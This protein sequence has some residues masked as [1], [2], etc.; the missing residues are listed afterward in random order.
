LNPVV[1]VVRVAQDG[2]FEGGVN[3][4]VVH[5]ETWIE[6]QL[7]Q[8]K[9]DNGEYAYTPTRNQTAISVDASDVSRL[10]FEGSSGTGHRFNIVESFRFTIADNP[11]LIS[12][13]SENVGLGH[14]FLRSMER[15]LALAYI[16]DLSGSAPWDELRILREELEKYQPGMSNKARVVIANKADLLQAD[17]PVTEE[18]AREKLRRLEEFVQAEMIISSGQATRTLDVVPTSAKYSQN[19]QKVV[20]LFKV[21]VEE[22][23]GLGSP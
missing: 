5:D 6:E 19:L 21:Y 18:G 4:T 22:A 23:R 1:G 10:A 16:V 2:T 17:D 7:K 13:A 15:S 14:S 20:G 9:M 8:E 3:G 12:G 11:G